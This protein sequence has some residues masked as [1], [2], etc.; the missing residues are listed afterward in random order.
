MA[1]NF[2]SVLPKGKRI[3]GKNLDF[4]LTTEDADKHDRDIN[5]PSW[6]NLTNQSE[7][8]DLPPP[9]KTSNFIKN[10]SKPQKQ[11][12]LQSSD[13]QGPPSRQSIDLLKSK[14]HTNG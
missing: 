13:G 14:S 4:R 2:A 7:H 10:G 6:D 3:S 1:K 5:L 12:T 9:Q 8:N 11:A